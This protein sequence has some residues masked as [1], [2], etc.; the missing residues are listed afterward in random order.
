MLW[1]RD[2]RQTILLGVPWLETRRVLVLSGGLERRFTQAAAPRDYTL[3]DL[4][5][6]DFYTGRTTALLAGLS[7]DNAQTYP[8]AISPVNG[9]RT[10]LTAWNRIRALDGERR[11]SGGAADLRGYV[12]LTPDFVAAAR[13]LGVRVSRGDFEIGPGNLVSVSGSDE[14]IQAERALLGAA[15]MRFRI[16]EIQRKAVW[17]WIFINRLHGAALFEHLSYRPG[18]NDDGGAGG[19]GRLISVGARLSADLTTGF[20]ALMSWDLIVAAP[21]RGDPKVTF[22]IST[23]F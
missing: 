5:E 10:Y 16:A 18:K 3:D 14:V 17:D 11:G 7:F 9:V 19:W 22:G 12:A 20:Y 21:S 13:A 1:R 15:E 4:P 23:A 8:L 2:R 6:P